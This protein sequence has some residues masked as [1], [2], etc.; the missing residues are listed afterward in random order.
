MI[1][2]K[3]TSQE[4]KSFFVWQNCIEA[5]SILRRG[6][7][8]YKRYFLDLFVVCFQI[9]SGRAANKNLSAAEFHIC[10]WRPYLN[11]RKASLGVFHARTNDDPI[12]HWHK[13]SSYEASH[14]FA[15]IKASDL[16]EHFPDHVFHRIKD[17]EELLWVTPVAKTV[18]NNIPS[19]TMGQ[20]VPPPEVP[21]SC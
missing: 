4:I 7:L 11:L 1:K 16:K 19:F 20:L 15:V 18:A 2:T 3:A 9:W 5:P 21:F 10:L 14:S 12:S 8:Y 13:A 6:T 17:K